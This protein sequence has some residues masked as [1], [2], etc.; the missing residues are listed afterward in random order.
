MLFESQLATE[1]DVIRLL[2]EIDPLVIARILAI[3][4]SVD[5]LDEAV[6]LAGD[7]RGFSEEPHDPSSTRVASIRAVLGSLLDDARAPDA[8]DEWR[9]S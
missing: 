1:A 8:R 2:G 6:Q 7:E 9:S 4:P 5:E 3:A